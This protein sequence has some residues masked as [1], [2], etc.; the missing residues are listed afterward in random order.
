MHISIAEVIIPDRKLDDQ[1]SEMS[2][3]INVLFPICPFFP[4]AVWK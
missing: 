3:Y 4:V 1:M 2:E